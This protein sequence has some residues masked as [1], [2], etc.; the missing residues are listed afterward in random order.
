MATSGPTTDWPDF[1]PERDGGCAV[2]LTET[3]QIAG[4]CTNCGKE[5]D[6]AIH[7][8]YHMDNGA[9]MVEHTERAVLEQIRR[10]DKRFKGRHIYELLQ[11]RPSEIKLGVVYEVD[12]NPPREVRV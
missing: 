5:I 9:L 11:L 10:N 2:A 6:M 7:S 4:Y 12:S 1:C 8:R 3:D